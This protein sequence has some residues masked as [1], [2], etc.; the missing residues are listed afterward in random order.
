VKT[1]IVQLCLAAAL[2]LAADDANTK[3]GDFAPKGGRFTVQMPGQPKEQT[4]K[5]NT[6]IG[7]I[8]VHLFVS[9]PDPNT[10]YIVGY[11]DYPEEMI[12]KSDSQKI[13]DGARDGAVKNVNGKLDSEK[14]ITIDGHPGRDFSI[15]TEHFEGRDRIYLVNNRLYQVMMV[16]SRDFV[17]SK[18]A[19]KFLDSFKLTE[20]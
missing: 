19:E 5:V 10:A 18:D 17:T 13:L 16:G 20:K 11:S 1:L 7:P 3:P 8:D 2:L 15:A 14:K 12:K 6:A 4:N 9:A